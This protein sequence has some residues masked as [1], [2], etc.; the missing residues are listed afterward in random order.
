[1]RLSNTCIILFLALWPIANGGHAAAAESCKPFSAQLATTASPPQVTSAYSSLAKILASVPDAS[2]V[3][4]LG[5]SLLAGWNPTLATDIPGKD[6]WNFSVGND[7][8]QHALWR[9]DKLKPGRQRTSAVV[10][11]LGTNNLVD[12]GMDGC[13]IY[14]GIKAVVKKAQT[15]WKDAPVFVF[16]VPPRGG[17]FQQ[18][19][20]ERKQLNS[21]IYNI[22][23]E[24]KGVYPI[25]IDDSEFTCSNYGKPALP[26]DVMYCVPDAIYRCVN[27][28]SDNIHFQESAFRY[29]KKKIS[30]ASIKV[31]GRDILQ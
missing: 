15:L 3:V 8:T 27:Y 5:D 28:K 10:V 4:L 23:S 18:K 30:G 22:S 26:S 20:E 14:E 7:R 25:V 1:M 31:M 9:M 13:G 17:D 19:D 24:M 16:T 21:R 12:G 11:L 29:L 2:D 6:I